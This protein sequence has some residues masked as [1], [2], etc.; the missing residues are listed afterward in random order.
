[1]SCLRPELSENSPSNIHAH[2]YTTKC[3]IQ[4][5]LHIP[6]L[7]TTQIKQF[8]KIPGDLVK[9]TRRFQH[10][11]RHLQV[12]FL[13]GFVWLQLAGINTDHLWKGFYFDSWP[14]KNKWPEVYFTTKGIAKERQ[15]WRVCYLQRYLQDALNSHQIALS[16][17][18]SCSS[19]EGILKELYYL[20]PHAFT[21]Q[22]G[23]SNCLQTSLLFIFKSG[24]GWV[25]S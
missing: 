12:K 21:E 15:G 23:L 7:A 3:C 14:R 4:Y 1:M 8:I 20:L 5:T 18:A 6:W 25:A 16:K 17:V 9:S 10:M 11:T 22:P 24:S 19:S 2:D 13:F